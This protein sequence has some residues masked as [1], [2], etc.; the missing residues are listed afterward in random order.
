MFRN[1]PRN[2]GYLLEVLKFERSSNTFS[3]SHHVSIKNL[4]PNKMSRI[5]IPEF[6]QISV[7]HLEQVVVDR[8]Q[9]VQKDSTCFPVFGLDYLEDSSRPTPMLFKEDSEFMYYPYGSSSFRNLDSLTVFPFSTNWYHFL[10]EGFSALISVER[11]LE[12]GPTLIGKSTPLN[13]RRVLEDFSG[14]SPVVLGYHESLQVQRLQIIQDW[15]FKDRF[16]FYSR[17]EDLRNLAHA[18]KGLYL[19]K[20]NQRKTKLNA[21]KGEVIFLRRP[22]GLFREMLHNEKTILELERSGV[23]VVEPSKLDLESL[24][25]TLVSA[26]V[27]IAETGAAITNLLFCNENTDFF[28]IQPAGVDHLFWKPFC[29]VLGIKHHS[30]PSPRGLIGSRAK[31]KFPLKSLIASL[32]SLHV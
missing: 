31:Y 10:V 28:E 22:S 3:D 12:L 5:E 21:L 2:R 18:L 27:V 19:E 30:V 23:I 11:K 26:R 1:A 7:R 9:F 29:Q 24:A 6:G 8:L 14:F 17:A 15:R 20:I 16:N 25:Q 32:N 13:I 4:T